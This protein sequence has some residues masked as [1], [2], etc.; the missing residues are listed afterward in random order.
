MKEW[1]SGL[2]PGLTRKIERCRGGTQT[3]EF[4]RN[5]KLRENHFLTAIDRCYET[6]DLPRTNNDLEHAF[7]SRRDHE[8]RARGRRRAW[9]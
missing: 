7:G 8:R 2:G 6:A 3:I 9:W 5:S 4:R 1:V